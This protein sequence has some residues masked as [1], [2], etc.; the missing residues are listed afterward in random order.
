[1]EELWIMAPFYDPG[2]R[3]LAAMLDRL[4]PRKVKLLI[5][6]GRTS[7]DPEALRSVLE[8]SSS[9]AEI[10]AISHALGDSPYFH[11]KLYLAKLPDRA[12][13]LQGSPNL[14]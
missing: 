3:A 1:M 9:V 5:Q 6:Q 7:A 14:S 4:H 11:A 12:V 8:H 10:L 13:C 2:A